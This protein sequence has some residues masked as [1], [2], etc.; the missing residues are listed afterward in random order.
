MQLS[1]TWSKTITDADSLQPGQN[2]GGGLYQDPFNLHL[3]KSIS[4]QDIPQM[5][6]GSFIY[7]LP[8][9]RNKSFLNRGGLVDA[10]F[11]GWQVGAILRYQ[12]GE[13][14]PFYCASNSFSPGWDDCFRFNPVPGQ[15]VYNAAIN[16][17][18]FNPLTQPYLNNGY[19]ADPNPNPSAPIVFGQ[20]SRVTGFR[21]Q[22]FFNEDVNL[23]KR[24]NIWENVN[25]ELRADAFNIANRHIFASPFNLNPSPNNPTTNFGYVNGTIDPPRT[26]QLEMRLRF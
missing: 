14:L 20:L 8:F 10:I 7:Q 24:F 11:G 4:S 5:F 21:M 16:Q 22:P 13:P 17:P 19:F 26:I 18:G 12:S 9:G 1:Y 2:A 25:L 3:E 6:V 15:S 23:V